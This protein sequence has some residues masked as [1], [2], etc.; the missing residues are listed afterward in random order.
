MDGQVFGTPSYMSPEQVVGKEIDARSDLFS[1]GVLLYE[2][3]SG[4]KP[5]SGDS[6][7]SITYA[8][9][10]T[11]PAKPQQC[12][13]SMWAVIRKA[14]DKSPML[15]YGSAQEMVTALK[16]AHKMDEAGAGMNQMFGL[17]QQQQQSTYQPY[18]QQSIQQQPSYVYNPYTNQSMPVPQQNVQ[19]P[20]IQTPYQPQPYMTQPY[21]STY[22]Y[23]QGYNQ[24][25]Y[26]PQQGTMPPPGFPPVYYPPPPRQPLMKPETADFLKRL[27]VALIVMG[28]LFAVILMGLNMLARAYQ[29]YQAEQQD[30]NVISSDDPRKP[31][32][33][34]IANLERERGRLHS[35]SKKADINRRIAALQA[36]LGVEA[37]NRQSIVEAEKLFKDA[38]T[39]DPNNP[40]LYTNLASL[41]EGQAKQAQDPDLWGQAAENWRH[42]WSRETESARKASYGEGA[43]NSYY[44]YARI[45]GYSGDPQGRGLAREALYE[46]KAT[47]PPNSQVYGLAT[48]MLDELLR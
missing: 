18:Q 22:G 17:G 6:V 3:I 31:L 1:V 27:T 16:E 33:E 40:T 2:M 36:Q 5:F 21:Q 19:S 46:A 10:N 15:R 29:N 39:N 28:T 12:G 9:M 7:V 24:G 42:A 4:S 32:P 20:P 48:Q 37:V 43:A 30:I 35:E 34:R 47:A 38:I 14:I 23:N 11:E 8:I 26:I 41:Y 13:D 25:T 44:M 45:V